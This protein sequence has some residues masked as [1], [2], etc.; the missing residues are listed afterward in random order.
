MDKRQAITLLKQA[1]PPNQLPPK[2]LQKL[3]EH[4]KL[5]M[6]PKDQ[7]LFKKDQKDNSA[8]YLLKGS[9]LLKTGKGNEVLRAGSIS[10]TTGKKPIHPLQ[11]RRCT[12]VAGEKSLILAID[13]QQL[14]IA[15]ALDQTPD[16]KGKLPES[17]DPADTDQ[18]DDWMTLILKSKAFIKIPPTNI[19]AMFMRVEKVSYKKGAVVIKQG[20]P[21]D[22]FYLVRQGKC[23]VTRTAPG[24]KEM[25]LAVLQRGAAFGEE[26]LLS[27]AAR[28]AN[29]KMLSDGILMRLSKKDFEQLLQEPMLRWVNLSEAQKMVRE[30]GARWLDVRL[31]AEHKENGF[32][33][34]L[35]I[36]L[37]MLRLKA[38]TLDPKGKYILY[39][40]S[41]RRSSTGAYLLNQQGM[42]AY[43]LR[44]GLEKVKT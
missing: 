25:Q 34:S 11:P 35:H 16:L 26:A 31:E 2:L 8:Y 39:C 12:A 40:D 4:T 42:E 22:Y 14:D 15:L 7:V 44:G 32:E 19:Q 6:V 23:A 5:L 17:E 10:A 30:S 29:V 33:G 36:P 27:G 24:G 38:D 20:D 41:G 9:I 18:T 13:R 1:F 3:C 28:N 21:G 37:I 43:C